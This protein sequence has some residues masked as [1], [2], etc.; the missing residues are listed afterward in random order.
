MGRIWALAGGLILGLLIILLLGPLGGLE[1]Q[2][3]SALCVGAGAAAAY[4]GSP[5]HMLARGLWLLV[6]VLLGALG[7]A[8]AAMIYPDT[9]IGLFLGGAVP[10]TLTALATMWTKRQVDF[11]CGVLASGALAGVYATRFDFDPQSLNYSLPI[12]M[13]QTL[14]PLGLGFL[15]AVLIQSF[16]PTDDEKAAEQAAAASSTQDADDSVDVDSTPATEVTS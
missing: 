3:T 8:L 1:L 13:G 10:I 7:F 6:G 16:L 12:A 11:L 14:L 15:A 2:L 4:L 9:N 5:S